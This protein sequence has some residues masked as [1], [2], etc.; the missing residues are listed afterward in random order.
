MSGIRNR[1]NK[2]NQEMESNFYYPSK[3]KYGM[4]TYVMR[5]NL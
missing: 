1:E 2:V 3:K 5:I 4:F